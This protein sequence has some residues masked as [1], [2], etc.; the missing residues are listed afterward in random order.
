MQAWRALVNYIIF[1]RP[2]REQFAVS[3]VS[4]LCTE[5]KMAYSITRQ[6]LVESLGRHNDDRFQLQLLHSLLITTQPDERAQSRAGSFCESLITTLT[7]KDKHKFQTAIADLP[8][9]LS[10]GSGNWRRL[11]SDLYTREKYCLWYLHHLPLSAR[12]N[13][14]LLLKSVHICELINNSIVNTNKFTSIKN[15]L[16]HVIHWHS[17][18]FRST[19]N[20]LLGVLHQISIPY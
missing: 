17:N 3:Q 7:S 19:S 16:S 8:T 4:T 13:L 12:P 11:F 20:H 1:F 2:Q 18:I 14:Y 10:L 5:R 6:C 15:T 9:C